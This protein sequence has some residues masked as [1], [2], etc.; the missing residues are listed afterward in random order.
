MHEVHTE[1]RLGAPSTIARTRCTLGFHRRFVRR[2]EWL[3]F[4]PNDG[5]LPQ[6]SHTDAMGG[7]FLR[8]AAVDGPGRPSRT[9]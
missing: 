4:I 7:T 8:E 9:A 6:I 2:W 1:M 3:T 5:F